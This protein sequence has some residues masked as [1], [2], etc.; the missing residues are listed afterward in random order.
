MTQS[1]QKKI[2][3]AVVKKPG[4]KMRSGKRYRDTPNRGVMQKNTILV[5]M[6]VVPCLSRKRGTLKLIRLSVRLSVY[7]GV[8][9]KL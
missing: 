6:F 5:A 7:P 2:F 8:S 9:Q 4:T 1:R 3:V